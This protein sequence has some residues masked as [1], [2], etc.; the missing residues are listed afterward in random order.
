M[1]ARDTVERDRTA[2]F[3]GTGL[4]ALTAGAA[5][6]LVFREAGGIRLPYG[7]GLDPWPLVTGALPSLLHAGS[8]TLL[9]AAALGA[10][11]RTLVAAAIGWTAIGW[12]FEALQ[13]PT[14]A[15]A[16]W[17]HPARLAGDD[18][19]ATIGTTMAAFAHRGTFDP[20]DVAA[21]AAGA[22]C[23]V[24]LGARRLGVRP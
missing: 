3:V 5:V 8:F 12:T 1:R 19:L 4:W 21:T 9:T 18:A 14:V 16:L 6:Y 22:A 2:S 24:A 23:A 13:H 11:R 7:L 20:L 15:N 10:G 17:P